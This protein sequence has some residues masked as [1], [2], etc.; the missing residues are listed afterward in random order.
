LDLPLVLLL[1]VYFFF[2][3][4]MQ[5]IENSLVARLTPRRFHH[6]AYGSKFAL[7]FGVGAGAV[8]T[9]EAIERSA[10]LEAVFP[11]LGVVSAALVATVVV[12]IRR[13]PG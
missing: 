8:K 6:A 7:T 4:G 5:P 12:L 3:L 2:L 13:E 10:G 1:V 9:V 11:F